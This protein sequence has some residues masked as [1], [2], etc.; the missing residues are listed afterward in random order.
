MQSWQ[1]TEMNSVTS[2]ETEKKVS[3]KLPC[4][5]ALHHYFLYWEPHTLWMDLPW[6]K[7]R[8]SLGTTPFCRW[9]HW[10]RVVKLLP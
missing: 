1:N 8:C 5:F 9:R 7:G 2:T 3:S 6:Q 4:A 10:G